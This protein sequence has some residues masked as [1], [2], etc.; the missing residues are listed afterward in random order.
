MTRDDRNDI[1]QS[2]MLFC[3]GLLMLSGCDVD[4]RHALAAAD[5]CAPCYGEPPGQVERCL[6]ECATVDD[7]PDT[8]GVGK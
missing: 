5:P 6:D 2:W 7:P 8:T 4:A 1:V 3:L